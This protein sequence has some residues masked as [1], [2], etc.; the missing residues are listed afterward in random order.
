MT[1]WGR[2]VTRWALLPAALV[3]LAGCA[4]AGSW[5]FGPADLFGKCTSVDERALKYV[6]WA[7]VPVVEIL[8][9]HG[10]YSPMILRLRQGWPYVL[11]I[12]NRDHE[13]RTIKS[14]E[15]FR[16]VAVVKASVNGEDEEWA[17]NG[18]IT[19]PP[20]QT[21][22]LRIVAVTDGYYEYEDTMMPIPGLF[23]TSPNGVIIIEERRPR[24]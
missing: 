15:F 19:V 10:E 23:S 8:V 20:R 11:R 14:F 18:A 7:R 4:G 16:R 5:G 6:N 21:A 17:C 24:I 22:E 3:V 13:N 1:G 9:R 2:S 12:R